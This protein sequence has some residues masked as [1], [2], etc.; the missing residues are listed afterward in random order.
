MQ[1]DRIVDIE[2]K[3]T[4][5]EDQVD[6]M[7]KVLFRQQQQIDQLTQALTSMAQRFRTLADSKEETSPAD[8]RPPHY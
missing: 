5:L 2:I 6:E 1:E 8:E 4:H 7:N 3:V